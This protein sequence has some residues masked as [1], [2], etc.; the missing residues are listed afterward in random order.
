[1]KSLILQMLQVDQKKRPSIDSILLKPF[2]YKFLSKEEQTRQT[3]K[4]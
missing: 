1:M 2:V 4:Q 3:G